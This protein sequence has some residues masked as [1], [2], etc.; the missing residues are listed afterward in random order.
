MQNPTKRAVINGLGSEDSTTQIKRLYEQLGIVAGVNLDALADVLT[1][2]NWLPG[3]V[4]ICWLAC[5][6]G[7][8]GWRATLYDTLQD[9]EDKRDDLTFVVR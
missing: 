9:A 5:P 2:A 7:R 6:S 8:S 3:P 4:V 1:D